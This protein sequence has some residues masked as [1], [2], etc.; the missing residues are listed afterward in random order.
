MKNVLASR[1]ST[2]TTP[3]GFW[4]PDSEPRSSPRWQSYFSHS[5]QRL[6]QP[7]P[8]RPSHYN[9][10][11][12]DTRLAFSLALYNTKIVQQNIHESN[13]PSD[14]VPVQPTLSGHQL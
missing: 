7:D 10:F 6:F 3:L 14:A 5:S 12:T 1:P 9:Q 11:S 2:F 13:L 4:L 8:Q